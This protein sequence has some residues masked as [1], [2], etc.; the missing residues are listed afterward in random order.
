TAGLVGR[1]GAPGV[2]AGSCRVA[3]RRVTVRADGAG[4][5]AGRARAVGAIGRFGPDQAAPL[6]GAR[7]GGWVRGFAFV[8][9]RPGG[10]GAQ[11]ARARAAGGRGRGTRD[12]F[13]QAAVP[14][15]GQAVRVLDA[16]GGRPELWPGSR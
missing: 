12:V 3:D 11:R 10:R 1:V 4:P 16:G 8:A 2:V 14:V 7:R 13:G 9:A 5:A 6:A 15:A